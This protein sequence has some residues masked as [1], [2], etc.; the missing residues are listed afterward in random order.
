MGVSL[1]FHCTRRWPEGN[2]R[3]SSDSFPLDD[4]GPA[5]LTLLQYAAKEGQEAP[6]KL[7]IQAGASLTAAGG[8][9]GSPAFLAAE[10]GRVKA[11]ELLVAAGFPINSTFGEGKTMLAAAAAGKKEAVDFLLKKGADTQSVDQYGRTPLHEAL[12]QG[13]PDVISLL[14]GKET[15]LKEKNKSSYLRAAMGKGDIALLDRL[16]SMG[17]NPR[18][19]EKDDPYI[20][21]P[22]HVAVATKRADLVE[23]LLQ[24]GADPNAHAGGG[25][26]PIHLLMMDGG[27]DALNILNITTP[28]SLVATTSSTFF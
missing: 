16:V 8:E 3:R 22:L 6:V 18:Y 21:T 1:D 24:L 15:R 12:T 7:L 5:G 2:F 19:Q 28:L 13:D 26:A 17:A 10:N 9:V 25:D 14:L 4:P 20:Y 27:T 23:F 11:L